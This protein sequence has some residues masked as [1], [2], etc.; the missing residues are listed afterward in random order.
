[1]GILKVKQNKQA[2]DQSGNYVDTNESITLNQID[3]IFIL[4]DEQPLTINEYEAGLNQ[5]K[6]AA[7]WVEKNKNQTRNK[8]KLVSGASGSTG[9]TTPLD[10][11]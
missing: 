7:E 1:M 11:G 10:I 5:G 6:F 2:K 4:K 9:S 8:Y 3:K